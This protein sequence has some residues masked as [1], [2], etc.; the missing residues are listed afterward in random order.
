[1]ATDD[2]SDIAKEDQLTE[3]DDWLTL[4]MHFVTNI[5]DIVHLLAS[6]P[7]LICQVRHALIMHLLG[8]ALDVMAH[9]MHH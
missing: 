1:M 5:M 9:V 6:S 7:N 3:V 4:A 8:G 2:E